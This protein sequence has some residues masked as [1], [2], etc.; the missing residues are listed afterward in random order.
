M[1]Y[2]LHYA[3]DSVLGH[4]GGYVDDPHDPGGCTKYGISS[5][6]Y[7]DLDITSLTREQA[8]EIYRSDYWDPCRCDELPSGVDL[9][10]FDCAVNQGRHAAIVILQQA[11]GA[12]VDGII[13]PQTITHAHA[14]RPDIVMRE[15]VALRG[16]RYGNLSTFP[17]FGLGWMRR[18]ADMHQK[19]IEIA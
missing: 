4:E 10:V 15:I 9:L 18:L 17:R 8:R 3:V 6:A 1:K 16:T 11:T 12:A 7:P 2:N 5:R 14:G 19:A 13:G